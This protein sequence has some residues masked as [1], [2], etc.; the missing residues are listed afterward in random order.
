MI[1]G[2]EDNALDEHVIQEALKTVQ[3]KKDMDALIIYGSGKVEFNTDPGFVAMNPKKLI[4]IGARIIHTSCVG[5][6]LDEKLINTKQWQ[7]AESMR[8]HSATFVKQV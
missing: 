8:S 3:D 7:E 6:R 4:L 5:Q 2:S 1:L